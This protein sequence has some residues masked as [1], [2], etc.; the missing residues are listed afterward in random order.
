MNFQKAIVIS[1]L[2]T[3]SCLAAPAKPAASEVPVVDAKL[4]T[5]V[6][7]QAG[8]SR[9]LQDTPLKALDETVETV[10]S[11]GQDSGFLSTE[12]L[13]R[14]AYYRKTGRWLTPHEARQALADPYDEG[15]W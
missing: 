6:G 8:Y 4:A 3:G 5:S 15:N 11:F 9:Y 13:F 7:D 12:G 14:Y 1:L 10:P 2:A